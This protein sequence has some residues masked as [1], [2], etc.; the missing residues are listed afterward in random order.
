MELIKKRHLTK[1]EESI[2]EELISKSNINLS[3]NWKEDLLVSDLDDGGMGSLSLYPPGVA[4]KKRKFGSLVSDC[5][6]KDT[7]GVTVVA[8]LY[9]DREGDMY[10][11]D[12][13]KTE[14]LFKFSSIIILFCAN[15]CLKKVLLT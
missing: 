9:L 4:G 8:S 15:G 2:L 11:L 1:Q 13:W 12:M 7:G 10:E 6:F 5:Q 14:N 3:F